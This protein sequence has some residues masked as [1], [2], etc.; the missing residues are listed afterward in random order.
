MKDLFKFL[1]ESLLDIDALDRATDKMMA[2][3]W[4]KENLR[5][6]YTLRKL[7][8]GNFKVYGDLILRG[9]NGNDFGGIVIDSLEGSLYIE[10]CPN[11]ESLDG[12]FAR[13]SW[14]DVSTKV[15]G[16]IK[17][18]NCKKFNSLKGMPNWIDGEFV[19]IDCPSLKSLE[20]APE[21]VSDVKIVKCGKKFNEKQ[22]KTHFK[23]A[24]HIMCSQE[25]YEN[26]ITEAMS[27]PHLLE[28]WDWIK[29]THPKLQAELDKVRKEE[30]WGSY[31]TK[32]I[33]PITLSLLTNGI[34]WDQVRPS[35]VT[36]YNNHKDKI[37]DIRKALLDV[38]NGGSIAI[39]KRMNTN[40]DYEYEYVGKGNG[41]KVYGFDLKEWQRINRWND[42]VERSYGK[43]EFCD[44]AGKKDGTINDWRIFIIIK[45][46]PE[47]QGNRYKMQRERSDARA[48]MVENTPEYYK[49]VAEAN[50][51]RWKE[52]IAKAK[53]M[54]VANEFLGVA[55]KIEPLIMRFAKMSQKMKDPKWVDDNRYSSAIENVSDRIKTAI[56]L[57]VEMMQHVYIAQG[58][59]ESSW[60]SK[61]GALRDARDEKNS[62]E[63]QIKKIEEYLNK[64]GL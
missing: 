7:K 60:T 18:S 20:G 32:E 39:V 14:G 6:K 49:K 11:L 52:M 27:E 4:A 55:Q 26:M 5:G 25:D 59:T 17:I 31:Y 42:S 33:R 9:Y 2:D 15:T 38:A 48:G 29:K 45:I 61:D 50:R 37:K 21:F 22:I 41:S 34:R 54:G 53:A 24:M 47:V 16:D 44:L 13:A 63:T 23:C 12:I 35:D 36:V 8:N 58:Q 62:L 40:G 30:N 57:S 46:D 19:C 64:L 1:H 51:K 10:D 3:T 56:K 43:M 28:F